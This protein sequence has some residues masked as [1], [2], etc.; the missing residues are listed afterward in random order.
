MLDPADFF[1]ADGPLAGCLPGY[2]ERDEQQQLAVAIGHAMDTNASLVCEAGTGTGKTF[3]YLLPAMQ[4]GRKVLVSTGTRHLQDQL[5]YKDLP[6]I[7]KA[8]GKPVNTA[9]LKGRANYLCRHR[10][11]AYEND[12]RHG[13]KSFRADLLALRRWLS[14]TRTGDLGEMTAMSEQSP[15]IPAVTSTTE[16]CLGQS[17]NYYE[18]CFVLKA[19][20]RANDADLVVVNHHLLLADLALRES[21]FAEVLPTAD[22]IVFDEA[23]QLPELA[24]GFFGTSISSRQLI[25][26]MNDCR[27]AWHSDAADVSGMQGLLDALG[28][29]V[30]QARLAFGVNDA[31]LAWHDIA[32]QPAVVR[33]MDNLLRELS[34]LE[35]V[36]DELAVRTRS[37]ENCWSRCNRLLGQLQSYLERESDDSIQWLELRGHGFLMHQTPLDVSGIFQSRLAQY[38]C[39][40]IYTS[41]TLAVDGD[42]SHFSSQLGLQDVPSRAWPSPFD[43]SQQALLYF[44]ENMPEPL[45]SGY[46]RAVIDAARPV[47]M[48][49]R[50]HTFLLFTSHRA[51]QEATDYLRQCIDYPIL[52]QGEAPR[53]ELLSVFRD[54]ANA[55]LLGTSSFW[56]GVDVKGQALSCVIIDKLPFAP[57]DDPVFRARSARMQEQG[58]NP[59]LDYQLPQAVISLKQGVGRLIRDPLDYGV[60]MICDPR[61]RSKPYGRVFRRSL[62]AMP[63]AQDLEAV[64]TFF[65]ERQSAN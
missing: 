21:G 18:D 63:L 33:A 54:T 34:A 32:V 11:E 59:F 4:S 29:A 46:T 25:A 1:S 60:L 16:N 39:E 47:I 43:F 12:N 9:L 44:P 17:C 22:Y 37:L 15:V 38:G 2:A 19:R 30:K 14:Q 8:L 65:R 13:G 24:A 62:P 52:V 58:M 23:H 53:S 40:C 49:S 56:E 31:R 10:L 61:I 3:A 20:R 5:F 7:S 45:S 55:V 27:L 50:G 64:E 28:V 26:L 57:P 42:F 36:L 6:V 51:L 41:A 35:K 48:A